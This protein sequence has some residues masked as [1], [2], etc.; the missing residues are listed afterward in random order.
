VNGDQLDGVPDPSA[1]L[2]ALSGGPGDYLR[3]DVRA[4]DCRGLHQVERDAGTIR[5]AR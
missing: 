2:W 1:E 3:I 4:T 5:V